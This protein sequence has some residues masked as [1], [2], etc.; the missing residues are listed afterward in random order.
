MLIGNTE[1]H[2]LLE[3]FLH[4]TMQKGYGPQFFLLVGPEGIG[5]ASYAEHLIK[6][7]IGEYGY[8]DL[9]HIKDYSSELGKEQS[10]PVETTATTQ[11]VE[12]PDG[13]R[14]RNYGIREINLWLQQSAFSAHKFLIIENMQRMSLSAM[15]AFLKTAEEPLP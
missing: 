6:N 10:I 4:T 7:I 12:L 5:K 14:E 2:K 3:T 13:R 8:S 1:A 9:L 11:F 15:N